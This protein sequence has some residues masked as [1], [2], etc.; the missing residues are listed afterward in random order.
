MKL[1]SLHLLKTSLE[2]ETLRNIARRINSA[3]SGDSGAGA[4]F[5]GSA[6]L[7]PASGI[8]GAAAWWRGA[9]TGAYHRST[10]ST[11]WTR[12]TH[13]IFY[14]VGI[15]VEK[16]NIIFSLTVVVTDWAGY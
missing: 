11:T 12:N 10:K 3:K 8:S 7:S 4:I 13:Y 16:P 5:T 2:H 9:N 6:H 15:V 14:G 1:E